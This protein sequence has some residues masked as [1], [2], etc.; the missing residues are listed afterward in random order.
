MAKKKYTFK[1]TAYLCDEDKDCSREDAL[2]DLKDWLK[3]YECD[4]GLMGYSIF[5]KIEIV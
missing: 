3:D 2:E 5:E 1:V 4:S